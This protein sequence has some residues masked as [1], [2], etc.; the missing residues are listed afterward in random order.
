M[1]HNRPLIF[2]LRHF[3]LDD[4]PGVRTTVFLKGCPLSCVWCHNPE[5]IKSGPEVSFHANLCIAC[6]DCEKTCP[7]SAID[8]E[9]VSR[10]V[11]ARC[12]ACGKCVEACPTTALKSVGTYYSVDS[13]IERLLDDH[14][15]Y[16]TSSGGVTF[17]G[18]EPTLHMDYVSEVMK[19]LK[20]RGIH[21]AIQTSGMFNLH[22][23][24]KKL[25]P[26]IDLV[27]YDI[28]LFDPEKHKA[29]VGRGTD[30]ILDNFTALAQRT[31]VEIIPRVPLVPDITATSD[32]LARIDNFLEGKRCG[33]CK[34]LAYNSG[35]AS[36]RV[37]LG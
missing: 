1:E 32:N 9:N 22:E 15:F 10:I 21:L 24:E 19:G 18:G 5:S 11:R 14:A 30:R 2:N 33:E 31:E 29:F 7:E 3:A 12:T 25:L 36:K 8:I 37:T 16:E 20:A 28:K 27:F 23:F 26:Y 17:S 4:G 6:G 35:G 34:F 13:L